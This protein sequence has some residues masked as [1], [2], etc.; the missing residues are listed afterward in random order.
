MKWI[1][2]IFLG[3]YVLAAALML[4]SAF[5]LFGQE[6]DP[7]SALFLLPLGLPWNVIADRLGIA[8]TASILLAPLVNAGLLYWLWKRMAG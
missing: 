5:G 8:G 1:F 6:N 3:L 2:F 4:I 7:L